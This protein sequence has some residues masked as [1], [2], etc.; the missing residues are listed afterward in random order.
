MHTMTPPSTAYAALFCSSDCFIVYWKLSNVFK[1]VEAEMG[2]SQHKKK[3]RRVDK[4]P[5]QL[6][7]AS[8]ELEDGPTGWEELEK[9]DDAPQQAGAMHFW[10]STRRFTL[11][12]ALGTQHNC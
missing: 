6:E 4:T 1:I 10:R 5:Q 3:R 12:Y 9:S 8:Q 2:E 7:H 11:N